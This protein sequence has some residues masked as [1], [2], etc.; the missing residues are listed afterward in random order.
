MLAVKSLCGGDESGKTLVFDE[1]DSGIGGRVAETVGRRL[2]TISER[3]QV[4]CVTHL[5]QIAAFAARHFHVSK[6]VAGNRTETSVRELDGPGRILELAR[7]LGGEVIT[8][9]TRRHARE[10]LDTAEGKQNR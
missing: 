9:I 5:P 8:D 1:V 10:M 7:M 2:R 6:E 3:N 4:L